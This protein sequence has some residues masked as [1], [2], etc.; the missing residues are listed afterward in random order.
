MIEHRARVLLL[1]VTAAGISAA[2][3][4]LFSDPPFP[5]PRHTPPA[6]DS[7]A[8]LGRIEAAGT[9]DQDAGPT[10]VGSDIFSATRA[11]PGQRYNPTAGGSESQVGAAASVSPYGP[12]P[13]PHLSGVLRSPTG[14]LALMQADSA[15]SVGR[16]YRTGDRIGGYRVVRID[17]SSVVVAGPRGRTRIR[18][19]P[20][21]TSR[22]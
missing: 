8:N 11:A 10:V 6:S 13:L 18:V 22:R 12:E 15:G 19:N 20:P 17:D 2:A 1:A 21:D 16:M 7:V 9:A 5:Q 4:L 3:L 14:A